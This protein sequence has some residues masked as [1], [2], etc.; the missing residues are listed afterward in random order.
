LLGLVGI[1][2]LALRAVNPALLAFMLRQFG[3]FAPEGAARTV[4][5][6]HPLTL[7]IAWS[8][9]TTSFFIS[10]IALVMLAYVAVK[11]RS[12]EKTVFLVW[13]VVMLAAIMGQRRFGY[14]FAVNAALLTGYFSWKMLD[15]AGL[16]RLTIRRAEPAASAGK[17]KK[18]KAREK[19]RPR[20][21]MQPRDAWVK[22]I[23][24]GTL[25]SF[26]VF[27]FPNF[28][29]TKYDTVTRE[30]SSGRVTLR[31]EIQITGMTTLLSTGR[32][33]IGDWLADGWHESCVWLR[34]HTPEPFGDPD[35]YYESYPAKADFEYPGTIYG[36]MSW[37]DY[38]YF[39]MQIGRRVPNAN[40]MQ[41]GAVQAGQFFTALD[42][43]SANEVADARGVGYVMIDHMMATT[44]FYAM[45]EWAG[46]SSSEFYDV[47]YW[48]TQDGR[49]TPVVLYHPAYFQ[50]TVV[51]LYSF[52]GKAVTP[53]ESIVIS[54]ED[55]VSREGVRYKEITDDKS[56]PTYQ[57]AR[58]Y[59]AARQTGNHI[60]VSGSRFSSPVPLEELTDYELV[61]ESEARVTI[62][63]TSVPGVKVFEYLGH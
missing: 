52:D 47:Y 3:I 19:A 41:A 8:N 16:R 32:H 36:V 1:T 53:T 39:I 59:I 10:F 54:Y 33:F 58:D 11:E 5:E 18:K 37:W 25:I 62:G 7:Q 15:L 38:G 21:F 6:M 48:A 49:L 9:F 28:V 29:P 40:P 34:D 45:A 26:A 24:V 46:K 20:R 50:S 30:W 17:I 35:F 12:A 44:K 2:L 56:F 13:C 51:R 43:D 22:V 57:E 4:L 27:H 61:Y 14:Y 31:Q 55:R 60:I 63:E 42:E 23:I